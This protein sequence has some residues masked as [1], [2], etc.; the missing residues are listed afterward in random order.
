MSLAREARR[1]LRAHRHG[2]LSTHSKAV[3]G[4]P[5][6]SVV[7]YVLDHEGYPLLLISRLAEHTKNLGADARASLLIHEL[8]NEN[9]G[10]V[11][12]QARVTLLGKAELVA[13]PESVEARY[14]R[15]FPETAGYRMQLDFDFWRIAPVTLR[16]KIGRAHV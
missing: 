7:P 13:D 6:G 11:L 12:A 3:E 14:T 16:A 10:N 15:Y 4:Y 5:F 2:L 8:G 9:E 1:W